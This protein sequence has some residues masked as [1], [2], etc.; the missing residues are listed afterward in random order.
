MLKLGTI[1]Y[2]KSVA[3]APLGLN[4]CSHL[5]PVSPPVQCSPGPFITNEG[6]CSVHYRL[7]TLHCTLYTVSI[8]TQVKGYIVKYSP[9]ELRKFLRAQS[10]EVPEDKAQDAFPRARGCI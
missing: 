4:C 6:V 9:H 1:L 2:I 8:L 7:Y 3:L 10:G 5:I